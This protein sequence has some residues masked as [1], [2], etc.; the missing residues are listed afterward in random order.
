MLFKITCDLRQKNL[1]AVKDLMSFELDIFQYVKF[2]CFFGHFCVF[3]INMIKNFKKMT[4]FSEYTTFYKI[5][6]GH[7][8]WEAQDATRR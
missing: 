3:N 2:F 7:F 6:V 4:E 5:L 8:T 1:R